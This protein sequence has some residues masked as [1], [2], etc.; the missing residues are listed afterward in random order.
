[1]SD[2]SLPGP[3]PPVS[4][5]GAADGMVYVYDSVRQ[6]PVLVPSLPIHTS[7]QGTEAGRMLVANGHEYVD[8]PCAPMLVGD[9]PP[10]AGAGVEGA[11]WLNRLTGLVHGPRGAEL[12]GAWPAQTRQALLRTA[13]GHALEAPL[14]LGGNALQGPAGVN[15]LR[16]TNFGNPASHVGLELVVGS[17]AGTPGGLGWTA[18]RPQGSNGA[19][20]K[21]LRLGGHQGGEVQDLAGS[22]FLVRA[23]WPSEVYWG[24]PAALGLDAGNPS[25]NL[26]CT[27]RRTVGAWS[28]A[29]GVWTVP[30]D[31]EYRLQFD[32][33]IDH[34]GGAASLRAEL[35]IDD[36]APAGGPCFSEA[37]AHGGHRSPLA[38]GARL[39]LP[40][41]SSVRLLMSQL[42]GDSQVIA[43]AGSVLLERIG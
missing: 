12:A 5:R 8:L 9:G 34:S 21:H 17:D 37:W 29:G 1:M 35:F 19:S 4:P 32:L 28:H 6:G 18:L 25:A 38:L 39:D 7:D 2:P 43:G 20:P 11:F 24:A 22:R 26:V 16:V 10:P 13:A 30:Q 15:A 14:V 27:A 31:G 3:Q 41:G 23:D 33:L 42:A 40:A 36:T